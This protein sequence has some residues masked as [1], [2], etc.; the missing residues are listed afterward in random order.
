MDAY[1]EALGYKPKKYGKEAAT[2]KQLAIEG[3]EPKDIVA[4]YEYYKADKFW[5]G[6]HLSLSYIHDNIAALQQGLLNGKPSMRNQLGGKSENNG[7]NNSLTPEEV[8]RIRADR[9][10][11]KAAAN[12]SP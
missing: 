9:L 2:A 6:K 3:Y 8:E 12:A 1:V 4:A 7:S 10:A 11:R 5:I